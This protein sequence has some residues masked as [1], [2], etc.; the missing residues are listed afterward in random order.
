MSSEDEEVDTDANLAFVLLLKE[1]PEVLEKSMAPDVLRKKNAGLVM[2]GSWTNLD[3][4]QVKKK[5]NNMKMRVKKIF[6]PT[7]TGNRPLPTSG[8]AFELKK[9]M[10]GQTEN[11]IFPGLSMGID[12]ASLPSP[13]SSISSFDDSAS[14]LPPSGPSTSTS[15][16][17]LLELL[18]ENPPRQQLRL[19]HQKCQKKI[20]LA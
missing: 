11:P 14:P 3:S 10:D 18:A 5:I 9:L 17:Y 4:K 12:T 20:H 13:S 2:I 15:A 1:A 16:G 6:D 19:A 7:A 8:W